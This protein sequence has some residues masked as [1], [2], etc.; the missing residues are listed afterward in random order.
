[1]NRKRYERALARLLDAQI[2]GTLTDDDEA[3][4]LAEL[5]RIW[6]RMTAPERGAVNLPTLADLVE[7]AR[8]NLGGDD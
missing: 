4:G 3:A 8:K 1:M 7:R 5:D 2:A 6:N